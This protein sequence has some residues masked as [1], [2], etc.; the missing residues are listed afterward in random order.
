MVDTDSGSSSAEQLSLFDACAMAIGGMVGGG[1]FAVLGVAV[2]QAGNAAFV[3]FGLAGLLA[4]VTGLSYSRLTLDFD[5]PGGSFSYIEEIIGARA[6]GTISWFLLLGYV[7]TISLYAHTFGAYAGRL[8]GVPAGW[9]PYV[10]SAIILLLAGVN[11]LGVRESGVIEDLLVYGK[12]AILLVVAGT[13]FFTVRSAEALPVFETG[14]GGVLGAAALIFV[15]YEGFQLLTYDYDDIA[16]RH[17]TLPRATWISIPVVILIYMLIAVVTTGGLDASVIRQHK[18]TVLAYAAQPVLGRAGFVAVLV[19]AVLS[20]ASAINA[21][22]FASARLA[23]RVAQDDQLPRF[24]TRWERG[25]VPVAFIVLSSLTALVV[26]FFGNLGQ[27]TTFSSLVFL[28][29]FAVVNAA[30]LWHRT[31]AGWRRLLPVAGGIGCLASAGLLAV[32][33]FRTEPTTVWIIAT[34]GTALILLRVLY[35]A[36][37]IDAPGQDAGRS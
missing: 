15:A 31:F 22:L 8:M 35:L 10:G 9:N 19:A 25:G 16:N 28:L 23:R 11:L 26:Q 6:S 12:V 1:I 13:G 14:M 7:F 24:M 33:T 17:T 4:L 29:V 27:I 36:G 2:D 18:E 21:T 20:T 5:E 30:A 32:N 3:S 34:I 37:S